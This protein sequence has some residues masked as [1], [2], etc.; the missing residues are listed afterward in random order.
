MKKLLFLLSL[1]VVSTLLL[2]GC[3][4]EECSHENLSLLGEAP[5]RTTAA[6]TYCPDCHNGSA[7][8]KLPKLTDSDFYEI[9]EIDSDTAICTCEVLG[10]EFTFYRSNFKFDFHFDEQVIDGYTVVGYEGS[11][12]SITIPGEFSDGRHGV[13]PVK[14]I[15][16]DSNTNR[17]GFAG[18]T[19]KQITIP[20][21][22]EQIGSGA[23][24]YCTALESVVI[25]DTVKVFHDRSFEGCSSLKT[26]TIPYIPE[27][28]NGFAD[29]FGNDNGDGAN[30]PTGLKEVIIT[31][32]TEL[33]T[34]A[35]SGC[36]NIETV[37]L[38]DTITSFGTFVFSGCSSLKNIN[39]PASLS[40]IDI[41]TFSDCSSLE[42]IVIPS[43][44]EEIKNTAFYNCTSLSNV[45]YEG[46]ASDWENI[47]IESTN[48]ECLANA[49]VL[50]YA[51]EAPSVIEFISAGE[52]LWH[53]NSDGEAELWDIQVEYTD[54]VSGKTYYYET[55]ELTVSDEYW[56]MLEQA[57]AE[58]MLEYVLDSETLYIYN[59][60]IDKNSFADQLIIN[61][62]QSYQNSLEIGF[63]DGRVTL[64]LDGEQAS[65]PVEYKEINGEI[66]YYPSS[67]KIAYTIWNGWIREDISNEYI[68]VIHV[69]RPDAL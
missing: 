43:S 34:C 25:P 55:T 67:E 69:Y 32:G 19:I 15:G 20:S 45:Y 14:Y 38:P 44:V 37:K 53:Y 29:I 42:S 39:I 64:Y 1:I 22:I 56:Y 46:S 6:E 30:V 4:G 12:S 2:V 49:D 58:G 33:E 16:K 35:F 48:N 41:G 57:K 8:I 26:I 11:N 40:T 31:G 65:Y 18:S 7:M 23:L 52:S 68:T 54:T 50:Y 27:E 60:S 28:N 66:I 47:S 10:K 3:G 5:T 51:E 24:G 62:Q 13:L 17:S 59:N 21:T 63:A 36:E 61:F 9:E